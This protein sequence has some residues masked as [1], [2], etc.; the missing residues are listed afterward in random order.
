MG[1][2]D[3]T[4]ARRELVAVTKRGG[5]WWWLTL[6]QCAV[7]GQRWLD[8]QEER[9]YDVWVMRK[10]RE[11]D[12]RRILDGDGEWPGDLDRYITLLRMARSEGRRVSW[13]DPLDPRTLQVLR[14]TLIQI[15]AEDPSVSRQQAAALLCLTAAQAR[16]VEHS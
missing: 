14:E 10:L 12:V 8:A 9:V 11:A 16:Q 3:A 2:D 7:C 13:A 5:R 1:D 4:D 15:R 6:A